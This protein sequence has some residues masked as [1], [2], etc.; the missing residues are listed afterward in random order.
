MKIMSFDSVGSHNGGEDTDMDGQAEE[1]SAYSGESEE[2]YFDDQ[3]LAGPMRVAKNEFKSGSITTEEFEHM[4][5]EFIEKYGQDGSDWST[6]KQFVQQYELALRYKY[7]K[8]LASKYQSRY[9]KIRSKSKKR[10]GLTV[11][12]SLEGEKALNAL[13]LF[14]LHATKPSIP[15]RSRLLDLLNDFLNFDHDMIQEVT[16]NGVT[17]SE[18]SKNDH[19]PNPISNPVSNGGNDHISN[20]TSNSVLNGPSPNFVDPEMYRSC[21]RPNEIRYKPTIEVL[22]SSFGRRDVQYNA[23]RGGGRA[24]GGRET[25]QD[26][27]RGRERGISQDGGRGRGRGAKQRHIGSTRATNEMLFN[28]QY[29]K[30]VD[31]LKNSKMSLVD[32]SGCIV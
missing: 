18:N 19:I 1:T 32:A 28:S 12:A 3:I 9:T 20:P 10:V 5:G 31:K 16:Q 7:E 11:V 23:S 2:V 24:V 29:V 8:E 17:L 27:G 13:V 30:G 6:L 14:P 26:G 15:P 25:S 4:W 21:G 22:Y